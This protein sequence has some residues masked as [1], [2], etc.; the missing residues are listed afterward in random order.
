[1][2][3]ATTN[4]THS[5]KPVTITAAATPQNLG[6]SLGLDDTTFTK[7]PQCVHFSV[8][9]RD[10]ANSIYIQE[11]AAAAAAD[12]VEVKA[13]DY[14][15]EPPSAGVMYDLR[16]YWIRATADGQKVVVKWKKA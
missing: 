8:Q 2:A 7:S 15:V 11:S 5:I 9:N 4:T 16:E 12:S 10:A 14:Y 3:P 13:G 6:D 1:M